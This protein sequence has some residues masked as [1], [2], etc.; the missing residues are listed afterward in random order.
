MSQPKDKDTGQLAFLGPAGE[1]RVELRTV[2]DGE[3]DL[4][5]EDWAARL[6]LEIAL[7][8]TPAVGPH[9][10]ATRTRELGGR[11]AM[12]AAKRARE[13]S[14]L[15]DDVAVVPCRS[16]GTEVPAGMAAHYCFTCKGA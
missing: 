5:Y 11:I 15:K 8:L 4:R 2:G 10:D 1:V 13:A 16:C 12:L 9:Y 6:S 14:A 3:H 7:I